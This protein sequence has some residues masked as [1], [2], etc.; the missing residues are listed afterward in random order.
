MVM[1]VEY[2]SLPRRKDSPS[3]KSMS[4][5]ATATFIASATLVL[6]SIAVIAVIGQQRAGPSV[7]GS[8]FAADIG[9]GLPYDT[10]NAPEGVKNI[11][12]SPEQA[13][14][15]IDEVLPTEAQAWEDQSDPAVGYAFKNPG[16]VT[17]ENG[18]AGYYDTVLHDGEETEVLPD[19][20]VNSAMEYDP[21]LAGTNSFWGDRGG[22][23]VKDPAPWSN[24]EPMTIA[25]YT[26]GDY[27][28]YSY[29]VGGPSH[30]SVGEE[31]EES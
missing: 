26:N 29:A 31:E 21:V 7:L 1:V 3:G 13:W 16:S 12:Y 14:E 11:W 9:S 5:R 10:T 24:N 27:V 6:G 15:G 4:L 17:S 23:N 18:W 28:P 25:E 19:E 30:S 22:Q 20:T 8:S 2:G